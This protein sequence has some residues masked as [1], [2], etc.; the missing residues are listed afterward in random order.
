MKGYVITAVV[1]LVVVAVV[2][3]IPAARAIVFATA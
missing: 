3:R 1:A 2:S